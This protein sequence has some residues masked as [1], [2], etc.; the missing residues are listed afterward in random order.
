MASIAHTLSRKRPRQ[1]RAK[2]LALPVALLVAASVL[3]AGVVAYL[4][5]PR[6][7]GPPVTLDTPALPITVAG[8]AFNIPPAAIRV[9][10]QRRP[11]AQD[12]VDLAFLWPSLTPPDPA[13][14]PVPVAPGDKSTDRLFVT[15]A[16]AGVTPP[17]EQRLR[18]LYPRYTGD[19]PAAA[20][21]G[22]VGRAFRA[23]TP[24]QGEDL[25]YDPQAPERFAV[26]CTRN[27]GA[28]LG[29]CLYQRRIGAAEVT[30]R[31]H[32]DWLDEWRGVALGIDELIGSL[33]PPA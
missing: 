10:V 31:F 12:R 4:L 15:L 9:K 5:W 8:T 20:P 11:G 25:L 30:V 23:G 33:R 27:T 16:D 2:S 22:L 6:W 26:R 21:D 14:K 24:Y 1:P 19:D 29:T 13:V 3:A 7:P 28:A 32:R 18:T 17:P